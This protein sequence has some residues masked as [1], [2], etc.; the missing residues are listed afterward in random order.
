M[1]LDGLDGLAD[2]GGDVEVAY[3][4]QQ[5]ALGVAPGEVAEELVDGLAELLFAFPDLALADGRRRT[6]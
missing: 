1:F 6:G 5:R 4:Q 2:D 3:E